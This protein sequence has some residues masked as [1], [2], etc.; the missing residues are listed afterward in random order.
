[1][2]DESMANGLLQHSQGHRPWNKP[3]VPRVWPTA[4]FNNDSPIRCPSCRTHRPGLANGYVQSFEPGPSQIEYGR[5][6][7]IDIAWTGPGALPL[8]MMNMAVGQNTRRIS[9]LKNCVEMIT[10]DRIKSSHRT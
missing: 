6:P 2:V 8:A 4:M 3:H 1:M 10:I 7:K 9:Q 5:W